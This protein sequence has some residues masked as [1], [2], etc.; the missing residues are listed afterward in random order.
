MTSLSLYER[1]GG[2]EKIR[3]IATDIYDNHAGN[4]AVMARFVK[5]DRAELI[6]LVKEFVCAGTD[7]PQKYAGK[8]MIAAHRGMNISEQEYLAVTDDI[9]AALDKN[10]VG[11]EEKR[12]ML[13]IAFSPKGE[14]LRQ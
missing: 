14:I 6:R 7:G 2:E 8:D 9:M 13:M 3:Q 11:D 12:E 4:G 10:G 1:L 5:T